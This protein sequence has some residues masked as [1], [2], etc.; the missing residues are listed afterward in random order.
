MKKALKLMAN[1][2]SSRGRKI[3]LNGIPAARIAVISLLPLSLP[4]VSMVA[5][6]AAMGIPSTTI[7][8]RSKTKRR[9][10]VR[11]GTDPSTSR[12]A[13]VNNRPTSSSRVPP[14]IPASTGVSISPNR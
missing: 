13:R 5:K 4:K 14:A 7:S 8:G 3:R 2:T 9:N 11:G 12:S 6:K 1:P 10:T